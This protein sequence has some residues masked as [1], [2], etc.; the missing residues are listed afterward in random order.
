MS[1]NEFLR[2]MKNI[3]QVITE[4]HQA[5][6]ESFFNVSAQSA[7]AIMTAQANL[8]TARDHMNDDA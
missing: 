8:K 7:L 1:H 4:I 6:T 5:Q 3:N 2:R